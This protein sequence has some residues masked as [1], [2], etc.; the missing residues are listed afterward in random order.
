MGNM[1]REAKIVPKSLPIRQSEW[2]RFR[3]GKYWF[4]AV[5]ESEGL[6]SPLC[7]DVGS[8]ARPFPYA[9]VLCDLYLTATLQRDMKEL[10]TK[11]KPFVLCD[12][13]F[14]PFKTQ[15]FDF[16]T[17]YYLFEHVD[18]PK[19]IYSELRRV[20]KHGYVQS[21]SWFNEEIMYG[22]HVHK[23]V[24][25]VRKGE[26]YSRSV[27]KSLRPILPFDYIFH[28]LYKRFFFWRLVHAILDELLNLFTARYYF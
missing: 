15:A 12:A 10:E 3:H 28:R 14:L 13:Q 5:V 22:E 1:I 20:S 11:G 24:M 6:D 17:C 25:I 7:L 21:P 19:R 27:W 2:D 26:L 18:D 23:W 4:F 8:G 16:A 9:N